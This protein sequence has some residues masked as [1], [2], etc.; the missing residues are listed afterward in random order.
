MAPHSINGKFKDHN[1]F[2]IIRLYDAYGRSNERPYGVSVVRVFND[3]A[4]GGHCCVGT[5]TAALLPP[6]M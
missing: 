4:V 5:E 2:I 1:Q 6:K 3:C